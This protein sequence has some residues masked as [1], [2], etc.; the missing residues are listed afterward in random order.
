MFE[1]AW[2][3]GGHEALLQAI[4]AVGRSCWKC[5]A[6]LGKPRWADRVGASRCLACHGQIA[7][8]YGWALARVDPKAFDER[9]RKRS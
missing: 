8:H 6:C 7:I 9:L 5:P 2:R 1:A 4:V 3:L